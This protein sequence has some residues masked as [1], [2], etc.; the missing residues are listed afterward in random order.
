MI[1]LEGFDIECSD[2]ILIF[3]N[4]FFFSL[5]RFAFEL[6]NELPIYMKLHFKGPQNKWLEFEYQFFLIILLRI[7]RDKNI[8]EFLRNRNFNLNELIN[9]LKESNPNNYFTFDRFIEASKGFWR[10]D[11]INWARIV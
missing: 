3:R 5:K 2:R 11:L 9:E 4:L 1:K 8:V 6:D 10:S 7:S